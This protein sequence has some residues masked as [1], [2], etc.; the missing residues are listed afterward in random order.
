MDNCVSSNS[1]AKKLGLW[2]SAAALVFSVCISIHPADSK[3]PQPISDI[4]QM[5]MPGISENLPVSPVITAEMTWLNEQ[6]WENSERWPRPTPVL[7]QKHRDIR[8]T[9]KKKAPV[10]AKQAEHLYR[11]IILRVSRRHEVDPAMVNAIIM[12]ESSFNPNAISKR[13]AVGLMQ[14]MPDTAKALGVKD[15]FDPE[16]NING[17]VLYFKRLLNEFQGN[18][19]LA[20]AAYDAGSRKVKEYQGVPPFKTTQLYIKKVFEYYQHYKNLS[21]HQDGRA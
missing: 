15:A 6:I 11:S 9:Q 10:R 13:G 20:L 19:K 21:A 2:I 12:A 1:T 3:P 17:G 8:I 16:H 7:P 5:S 18:V 4:H 14:L